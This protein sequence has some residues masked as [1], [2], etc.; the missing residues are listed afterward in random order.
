MNVERYGEI[1]A[2]EHEWDELA[3]RCDAPPWLRPGWV[4]AWW[5]AFGT[6]R[7]EIVTVRADGRLAGLV[8]IVRR[9]RTLASITNW[10]TPGFALLAESPAVGMPL[11]RA[12]FM[13]RPR[14]VSLSFLE[15]ESDVE[16]CRSS[17]A[18]AGYRVLERTVQ[19]SPYVTLEGDWARYEKRL[20]RPLR[21]DVQ[22]RRRRLE[23]HGGIAV[24]FRDGRDRLDALLEEGFRIEG[25]GWKDARGT[26]ISSS[27]QTRA[28]YTSVA[29]WASSRGWLRLIFL[30]VG[31]RPVAFELAFEANGVLYDL[32]GGYDPEYGRYSP[33]KLLLEAILKYGFDTGL[34]RYEFLGAETPWK[35]QW[36]DEVKDLRLLQAFAPSGTGRV[37]WAAFAYGRRAAKRALALMGR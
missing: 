6:G 19:R 8:P 26:A 4:D 36:T 16:A 14:R 7:L 34:T 31:T 23:E 22:R 17:A 28:F 15:R 5:R 1:D 9:G 24:E 29:R 11:A 33:G 25:S 37:D 35:R 30:R 3:D 32:K 10:H 20:S 18:A 12:L 21:K 27:S 13:D 2:V